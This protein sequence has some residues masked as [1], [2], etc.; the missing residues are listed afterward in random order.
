MTGGTGTN[1]T[2]FCGD[3]Y[4]YM[5]EQCD[6]GN[7]VS[8]DGCAA[9]CVIEFIPNCG[10]YQLDGGEE[11]DEGPRGTQ[12]CTPRCKFPSG[13][14]ACGDNQIQ[15]NSAED[16]DDGN[17]VAGDG[18][19]PDCRLEASINC[20]DGVLEPGT[21]QCDEGTANSDT[22]PSSCRENCVLPRCGDG[23]LD[24]N[25]Q[26][27]VALNRINCSDTCELLTAGAP[28]NRPVQGGQVLPSKIPPATRTPTG[29]GLVIFLAS[30]AAAGVGLVRRRF[31]SA[32]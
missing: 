8:G 31:G 24:F 1:D 21:E 7:N 11:C 32:S 5:G 29:P 28:I 25:E 22:R 23:V 2:L 12:T 20:G 9:T 19:S 26:C 10:N 3:G 15:S 27:D 16:C 14:G 18:C 17:R 30:G 4:I 13:Y 6:D